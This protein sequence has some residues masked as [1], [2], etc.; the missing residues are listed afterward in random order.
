MPEEWRSM[1]VE[2]TEDMNKTFREENVDVVVNGDQTFVKFCPE[3]EEV[4][5]PKGIKRIGGKV[6]SI[7]ETSLSRF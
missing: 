6:R 7:F 3:E 1:S 4:V 5:A 2:N